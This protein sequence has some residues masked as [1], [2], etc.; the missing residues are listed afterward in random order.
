MQLN[1]FEISYGSLRESK[2]LLYFSL[3]R[4]Y[5]TQAKHDIGFTLV[6]EIGK[7]LWSEITKL[8]SSIKK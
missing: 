8:E 2:Y 7:M 3:K 1:F 5:I 4:N 6:E